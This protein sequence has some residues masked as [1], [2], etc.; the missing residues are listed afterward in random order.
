[1]KKLVNSFLARFNL[2]LHGRNY[3]KKLEK[4]GSQKDP[5][6]TQLLWCGKPGVIFDVGANRGHVT[7]RYR[8]LYP[9]ATIHAFEPLPDFQE[10]FHSHHRSDANVRLARMALAENKGTKPFYVNRSADTSSL[11][12]SVKIGATSDTACQTQQTVSVETTTID[13]YL[14]QNG[15]AK[16]DILKMDA[17][18]G[19]LQV[20]KGAKKA[21]EEKRI[22]LIYTEAFFQEQYEAQPLLY[23]LASFLRSYNYFL[24]DIYEPYYNKDFILW[25]DAIFLPK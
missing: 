6:Q 22:G 16:I 13:H 10:E 3:I 14:E 2:A 9:D 15:I 21:L 23:D 24:E 19:E 18:G 20:L 17:Q 12:R 4:A 8:Q 11:L 1:M 5:F 7:L 25:C